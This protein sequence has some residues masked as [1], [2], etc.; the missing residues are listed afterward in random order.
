[1]AVLLAL[2]LCG[3]CTAF[4]ASLAVSAGTSTGWSQSCSHTSRTAAASDD[5]YV[6]DGATGT[7]F[8][9][10]T[11]LK[12]GAP[13]VLLGI[14]SNSRSLVRFTLP[15]SVGL[16]PITL[17]KLRLFSTVNS[18][19]G[20]T[21]QVR[22]ANASWAEGTVT[23]SNQPAATGTAVTTTS[24]AG[25][26]EWTVTDHVTSM[27]AS[28]NNGFIVRDNSESYV[29]SLLQEQQYSS[30]EAAGDQPELVITYG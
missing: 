25:W 18:A 7:N 8:G 2:S 1:V 19:L 20:R 26:V 29:I 28:P 21:L 3:V 15:S 4:A 30:S 12:V 16:C 6:N 22:M 9:N 14:G 11:V 13:F 27:Y 10:A 24:A 5:S 23:W 17:A